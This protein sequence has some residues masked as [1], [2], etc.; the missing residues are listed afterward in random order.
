MAAKRVVG[1]GLCVRDL[2]F[3]VDSYDFVAVRVRYTRQ[4]ELP[5]GMIANATAQAARLGC[6][7]HVL[8]QLGD[9]RAGRAIAR[10]LR[11]IGVRTR[12]LVFS[13]ELPTTLSL[14][15]VEARSGERRFL[16]ADRRTLERRGPDFD[17]TP[18]DSRAVLLVDGHFPRQAL[19]AAKR[20][21]AADAV[22]VADFN[23]PSAIALR[24]L[25]HCDFPIVAEEFARE[26]GEGDS[27]LALRRIRERAPRS[28]PV[29]TLG[30]RGALWHD[31]ARIRKLP[32]RRARVID[33]TGAGDAY[34]GAFCAGIAKGYSVED[35]LA[36]AARAGAIACTALGGQ[37]RQLL[38]SEL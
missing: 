25:P 10:E 8:S 11:R 18:I 38:A 37:T 21:R 23:R 17:L 34:H 36:L 1:L 14:C 32:P 15:F 24:L 31:G 9:D 27:R 30:A 13:R 6:E 5:G 2:V 33:T 29:V 35:A 7:T 16:V 19:A 20:A 28:Q 22:V 12:R 26:L 3:V 4:L